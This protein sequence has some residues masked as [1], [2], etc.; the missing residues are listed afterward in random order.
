MYEPQGANKISHFSSP[1]A[2]SGRAVT[3]RR[4]PHSGVMEDFL[5]CRP[6]FF[7]YENG[8]NLESFAKKK[9][10]SS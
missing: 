2:E 5:V 10:P 7:F 3:G 1:S 8:R 6:F 4:F 9:V